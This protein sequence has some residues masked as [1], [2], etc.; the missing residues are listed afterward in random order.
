MLARLGYQVAQDGQRNETTQ[1]VIAAFQM[2]YR[3]SC[4]DG[5][6]DA[7]TA[8]LLAVLNQAN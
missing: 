6:V 4:Y 8:A 3:P 2:R 5:L 7:Q 1:R